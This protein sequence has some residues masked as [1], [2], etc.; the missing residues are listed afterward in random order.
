MES[1]EILRR[2]GSGAEGD[3]FL[4]KQ[5]QH[6]RRRFVMK[7]IW[8]GKRQRSSLQEAEILKKLDHR[9]VIKYYDSFL[10]PAGEHL[11]IITDYCA[12]GN[13]QDRILHK[14]ESGEHFPEAQIMEWFGQIVLAL[15]YIHSKRILHRDLKTANIFL[16]EHNLIKVGDF[17]I[18]AQLEHSFDVKHTCVGSP[19]YMSPE[20]CQDIPYNTKS[21]IWAL[22]CVL[23]EMCELTQAFKG[24]NLLA[25]V[26][27]ICNCQYQPVSDRYSE[28]LRFLV[29]DM[30]N[31]KPEERPSTVALMVHS[32]VKECFAIMVAKDWRPACGKID[33][34]Q[35]SSFQQAINRQLSA[36]AEEEED[37]FDE[38]QTVSATMTLRGS[39]LSEQVT[40]QPFAFVVVGN[41]SKVSNRPE[42]IGS[43]V[44]RQAR[45]RLAHPA[46]HQSSQ[47]SSAPQA[48]QRVRRSLSKPSISSMSPPRH[49][50]PRLTRSTSTSNATD[51][52][53]PPILGPDGVSK[54]SDG[55]LPVE[56]V[57]T[58]DPRPRTRSDG[59]MCE[60]QL[61][62]P[63][64]ERLRATKQPPSR[65]SSYRSVAMSLVPTQ[66]P[67]GLS[68]SG[69]PTTDHQPS[70]SVS[71][72][73]ANRNRDVKVSTAVPELGHITNSSSP[74]KAKASTKMKRKSQKK[75]TVSQAS[76]MTAPRKEPRVRARKGPRRVTKRCAAPTPNTASSH[77]VL[78]VPPVSLD[79]CVHA[80]S[81][82]DANHPASMHPSDDLASATK[83]P[84]DT[85]EEAEAIQLETMYLQ[86]PF[87][88]VSSSGTASDDEEDHGHP[89]LKAQGQTAS[90]VQR[91]PH[92]IH[93]AFGQDDNS[94]E[95]GADSL[96]EQE[97]GDL[98]A[99]RR[100][101]DQGM[102]APSSLD[103]TSEPAQ[104]SFPVPEASRFASAISD[105]EDQENNAD[106][107]DEEEYDLIEAMSL[108]RI[109][110]ES[111][112]EDY[113]DEILV[114]DERIEA[115]WKT[116]LIQECVAALGK[117]VFD[118]IHEYYKDLRVTHPI[119]FE[120]NQDFG[121]SERDGPR[122]R[123]QSLRK[124]GEDEQRTILLNMRDTD[125]ALLFSSEV[126]ALVGA[127]FEK[128]NACLSIRDLLCFDSCLCSPLHGTQTS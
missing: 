32:Y 20:V 102:I 67:S 108:A 50:G 5:R 36:S 98:P 111:R 43:P 14:F 9:H 128:Q 78:Q 68:Q 94:S 74:R 86:E 113:E 38:T 69:K 106:D 121:D 30:L 7:K 19:Y 124:R 84:S 122:S 6:Q 119:L 52:L 4:V 115:P 100:E 1:Y 97:E 56:T 73:T 21:D 88:A 34:P 104:V 114:E 57:L 80:A 31:P 87:E 99:Q 91:S 17:G 85:L 22:G 2:I 93:E 118:F 51:R 123:T 117:E 33:S 101:M 127:D 72:S 47:P 89:H 44:I 42:R 110:L 125:R 55:V 35:S 75:T 26:Q 59:D 18:A 37:T 61:S 107:D 41:R 3:V 77:N 53:L 70:P 103:Q 83:T 60:T 79:N 71:T 46:S 12:G 105:D 62:S 112:A 76:N 65:P 45:P 28:G 48:S 96:D 95:Y 10:D 24:S 58:A 49:V 40:D 23:Y 120:R 109:A 126:R 66:V 15:R 29:K 8:I 16:T 63:A 25:L 39:N 54:S 13:L 11:C 116:V 81:A 82:L 64:R 27:K 92:P 90:T